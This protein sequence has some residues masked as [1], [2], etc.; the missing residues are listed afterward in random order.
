MEV[1][2][3]GRKGVRCN[4]LC[5]VLDT[6]KWLDNGVQNVEEQ[7]LAIMTKRFSERVKDKRWE[8]Q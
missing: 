3:T 2:D 6:G 4:S 5:A 7:M 8:H 1:L